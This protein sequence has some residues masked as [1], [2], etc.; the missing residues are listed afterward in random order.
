MSVFLWDFFPTGSCRPQQHPPLQGLY[1]HAIPGVVSNE[2][3]AWQMEKF[4]KLFM[5]SCVIYVKTKKLHQ[6]L[7]FFP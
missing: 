2:G 5:V 6:V 7:G 1:L 4:F 3:I